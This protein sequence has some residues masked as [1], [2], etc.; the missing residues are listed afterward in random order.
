MTERPG[1]SGGMQ[2]EPEPK[3][4]SKVRFKHK[5]KYQ[6][7]TP[8]DRLARDRFTGKLACTL[9]TRT[10]LHVGSGIYELA[11]SG[12]VR[13]LITAD[14][15][16]VVPGTSLKGAI[17]S[18]AEAISDSCVR[19]VRSEIERN[20]SMPEAKACKEVKS[21]HRDQQAKRDPHLCVCC[22]LFGGL[23][24]QG[25]V[26]FTDARLA[27][28]NMETH[29]IRSPYPPRERAWGY[30]DARQRFDG[31]KFY[32]H[33]E[34]VSVSDGEPYL[35]IAADSELDF[36]LNF[37]NLT[38]EEFCLMLTAMGILDDFVIKIGG[39]KQAMLG[40]VEIFPNRL[41]LLTSGAFESFTAGVR[42][43][44]ER[45]NDELVGLVGEAAGIVN[46]DALAE[47]MKIW[48]WPSA[49]KAPTGMY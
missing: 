31:R 23:G 35:V 12:P 8:H 6:A 22:A 3:P 36:E 28:G 16:V 13:G 14:G 40:S 48:E 19:I 45:V 33:G 18:I 37:E 5:P 47:L 4:F 21:R 17:R 46:K 2:D 41:E 1:R 15:M 24:Y 27:A 29:N 9:E 25:R 34:P 20:L 10:Q 32:Y 26:S 11:N 39:G 44:E 30:Q 49:R 7:V 43:I 42:V 38:A